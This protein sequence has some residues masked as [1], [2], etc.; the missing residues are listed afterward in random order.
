[1]RLTAAIALGFLAVG[2]G[3]AYAQSYYGYNDTATPV[4]ADAPLTAANGMTLYTFDKDTTGVSNCDDNC[5]VNWPPYL[6][7]AGEPASEDGLTVITRADGTQ[8]WAKDG[9]P[10]YFWVG[11]T[12]PGDTNGDGVGGVWHIA[13]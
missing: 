4:S 8:Q 13:H 5:A 9:A 11:D 7:T 10:L 1:M 6:P 12:A 3:E 2:C